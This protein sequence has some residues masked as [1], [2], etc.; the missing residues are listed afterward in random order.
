MIYKTAGLVEQHKLDPHS[1]DMSPRFT[2]YPTP[3][4]HVYFLADP[5]MLRRMER[6]GVWVMVRRPGRYGSLP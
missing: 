6:L 1:T 3:A 2:S 4:I 5:P